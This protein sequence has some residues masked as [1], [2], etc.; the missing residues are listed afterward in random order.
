MTNDSKSNRVV[1]VEF[2]KNDYKELNEVIDYLQAQSISTVTKDDTI[3]YLV[4]YAY[5]KL[6]LGEDRK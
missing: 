2:D 6:V 1:S 3:K 5:K 4:K